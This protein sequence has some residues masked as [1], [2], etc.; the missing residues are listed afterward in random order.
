MNSPGP[1]NQDGPFTK[2]AEV[3]LTCH[4]PRRV[5]QRSPRYRTAGLRLL[6]AASKAA[7]S[8]W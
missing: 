4:P 7:A 3:L 2:L 1:E 5:N 6:D 8:Q